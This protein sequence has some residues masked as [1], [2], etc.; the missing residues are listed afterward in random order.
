MEYNFFLYEPGKGEAE[1]PCTGC[2]G[3]GGG[4]GGGEPLYEIPASKG[5]GAQMMH[6]ALTVCPHCLL[7]KRGW[8]W[9]KG[10]SF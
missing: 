10:D 9:E 3:P 6:K 4:R 1:G 2:G 7:H 5:L 8:D